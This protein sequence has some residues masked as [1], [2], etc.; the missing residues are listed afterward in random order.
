MDKK[1]TRIDTWKGEAFSG[2]LYLVI[3]ITRVRQKGG[4]KQG[5]KACSS[6]T[7]SLINSERL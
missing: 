2:Y 4:P 3:V 5:R 6:K 7:L 1:E